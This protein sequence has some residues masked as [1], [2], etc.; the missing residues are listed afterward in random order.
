[1]TPPFAETTPRRAALASI[2]AA[3]AGA[4]IE[5]PQREARALLCAILGLAPA[6]LIL[7]PEAPLGVAAARLAEALRRRASREPFA[8]ITG[9]REFYGL[10]FALSPATLIPRPDSET[11]VDAVRDHIARQGRT[12]APLRLVDLGTGT[13]ALLIALLAHLP[14]AQGTGVD[15]SVGALETAAANAG[16]HLAPG[17][18]SFLH[19]DWF[20]AVN[21]LFD[22]IVSNPPYIETGDIAALEPEVARH[23]PALA[24]D[25]GADGLAAY[26]LLARQAPAHLAPGGLIALEL[27]AGQADAVAALLAA[28]GFRVAELRADLGG[29]PRALLL[30][31]D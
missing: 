21:G 24:L 25:G 10:E 15:L 4:G 6:D 26:R 8:R 12:E 31:R 17:R 14:Q 28:E 2:T 16:R 27:G 19:S 30:T 9:S 18:A 7:T 29:V 3:L 5:D 22:V 11:L 13:G 23:D 20:A 1:M